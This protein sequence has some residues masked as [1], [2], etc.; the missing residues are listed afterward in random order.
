[1][2]YDDMAS[3]KVNGIDFPLNLSSASYD[4]KVVCGIS[5]GPDGI[6]F[7]EGILVGADNTTGGN[8]SYQNV[9]LNTT[10]VSS[11]TITGISGAGWG[12]VGVSVNCPP[13]KN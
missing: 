6:I 5:P 13:L 11:I 7:K 1:M 8:Y 2:N 9:Q 12:F 3:I 10:N 4:T